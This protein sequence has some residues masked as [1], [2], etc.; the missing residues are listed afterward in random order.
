MASGFLVELSIGIDNLPNRDTIGL[1][2]PYYQV[3][4]QNEILYTSEVHREKINHIIWQP[5]RFRIPRTAILRDLLFVVMDK[6]RGI[7]NKDECLVKFKLKFPFRYEHNYLGEIPDNRKYKNGGKSCNLRLY[8]S[9]FYEKLNL[10]TIDFPFDALLC[11]RVLLGENE[12]DL[13]YVSEPVKG[14]LQV[15]DDPES[16]F[17]HK[18]LF[19]G[20]D[21]AGLRIPTTFLGRKLKIELFCIEELNEEEGKEEDPNEEQPELYTSFTLTKKYRYVSFQNQYEEIISGDKTGSCY[22]EWPFIGKGKYSLEGFPEECKLELMNN[23]I[24]ES[25]MP[26]DFRRTDLIVSTLH[27]DYEKNAEIFKPKMIEFCADLE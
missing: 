21:R 16:K 9:Y 11:Y 26:A 7:L 27:G 22:I 24:D 6:D 17:T 4:F 15:E 10:R 5:E 13:L 14:N 2:D 23:T 8:S 20:Q 25:S 3:I 19:A 18:W 1:S 12:N